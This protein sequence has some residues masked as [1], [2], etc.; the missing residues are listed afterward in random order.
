MENGSNILMRR[1]IA[2]LLLAGFVLLVLN[3]AFI[4]FYRAESFIA[5]LIIMFFYLFSSMKKK[6]Q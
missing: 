2:W 1:V 3:I 5:Y 6:R 4:G